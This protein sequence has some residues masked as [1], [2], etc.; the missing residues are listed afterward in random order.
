MSTPDTHRKSDF[1]ELPDLPLYARGSRDASETHSIYRNP[2][3]DP[4]VLE[5]W[6]SE[7]MQCICLAATAAVI[8][9]LLVPINDAALPCVFKMIDQLWIDKLVHLLLFAVLT[10]L[11]CCVFLPSCR[12]P[13]KTFEYITPFRLFLIVGS[14]GI[15][16]VSTEFAQPYFGRSFDWVD[17]LVDVI[18]IAPGFGLFLVFNEVRHKSVCSRDK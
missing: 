3:D 9:M 16:A 13:M 4:E 14:I 2:A 18:S 17:M 12:N 5:S 15:L 1:H 10:G 11:Y 6:G 7:R 8:L